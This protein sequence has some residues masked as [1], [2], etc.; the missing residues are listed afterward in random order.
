MNYLSPIYTELTECQDC[1]KCVRKCPVKA[2]RVENGHAMIIPEQCIMC[3]RCVI[4][5]PAKAKH[6]RDD[7]SRAKQIL[8][9]KKQV[10]VSLAPSFVSEFPDCTPR[11]M[12]KA[13]KCLGFSTVSET[14]I[15][16]DIISA[17]IT[18]DLLAAVTDADDTSSLVASKNGTKKKHRQMLFLSS[19]CPVIV[20]YIKHYLPEYTEFITDRASPLL[21]NARFIKKNLAVG[22]ISEGDLGVVFIGPCI[23][24]KREADSWS[25]IDVVIT[26]NDLRRWFESEKI[27]PSKIEDDGESPEFFP[28]RA[29]KGSYYPVDGGMINAC[30]QYGDLSKVRTMAVSGIDEVSATLDGLKNE[31]LEAPLFIEFLSCP[32]GCINGPGTAAHV[33]TALK[34]MNIEKYASTAD[35]VID[36]ATLKARPLITDTLPVPATDRL[37]H[38]DEEIRAALRSV[39]K[40][41]A[42]DELNCASC[43]Y[44]TCRLFAEAMLDKHAEKTM[45]VSYM[46]KL[47]QKKANGLIQAIPSGVVIVDKDLK[48]VECN[49]NFAVLLGE[50]AID[51]F[52][53]KPGMEGAD[54]TKMASFSR[55]FKDVLAMNGPEVIDRD[56]RENGKVFHVSVFAIEKEVIAAGVIGDITAPRN[57]KTR[58]IAQAQKVIGKTLSVVQQIAFLLGENAA[59]TESTLNSII[60]SFNDGEPV[61]DLIPNG[62]DSGGDNRNV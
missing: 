20:E 4:N 39:G 19:A 36:D 59:E 15:G 8:L 51:I 42:T 53:A 58:T 22:G 32:G 25:E 10:I 2:I 54:L 55:F 48:I 3:G 41:T 24:K 56:V 31:N 12:E 49:R 52:D 28:R 13:L 5:C 17:Q 23:A 1:Y 14:A 47:A 6:V 62:P 16:A 30:R 40:Y 37:V 7:L 34:R 35:D 33:S 29:A 50:D 18:Q 38:S 9:L 21:A 46:R 57:Q 45:C 26:F 43:G 44:D 61:D 60:E 11:Q 27:D